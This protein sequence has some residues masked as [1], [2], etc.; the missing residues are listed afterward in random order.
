MQIKIVTPPLND[1]DGLRA[2]FE[3]IVDCARALG[4]VID[5]DGFAMTWAADNTRVVLARG[6]DGQ[7]A[8]MGVMC[9]GRRWYDDETTGS[10][11][12]LTGPARKQ[13]MDYYLQIAPI[14]G[15]SHIYLQKEPGDAW[16]GE[17]VA[18]VKIKV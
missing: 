4:Q 8:G 9:Y 10:V 3:E 12:M 16:E 2:N 7:W 11:I 15:V 18:M 17:T 13:V 1:P 14:L 6:D 5:T